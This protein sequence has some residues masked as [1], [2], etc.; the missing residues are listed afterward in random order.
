MSGGPQQGLVIHGPGGDLVGRLF[1]AA[2]GCPGPTV[3]FAHG[4]PG[5]DQPYDLA[6]GLREAGW[7]A[8]VWHYRGCWGSSGTFSIAGMLSDIAAVVTDLCSGRHPEVDPGRLVIAGHSFGSWA[9]ITAALDDPR[10]RA[11]AAYGVVPEPSWCEDSL[12][13]LTAHCVP[14]LHGIT[15]AEYLEQYRAIDAS[16]SPVKRIAELAPRPLLLLHGGADTGVPASDA[17]KLFDRAA[18]PRELRIHPDA[19]HDFTGARH[20]LLAQ[21]TEWLG[22]AGLGPAEG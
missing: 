3:V 14:W 6:V 21:L 22:G 19:D 7:N 15:A 5:I 1:A 18:Q 2:P 20:W 10:I 17:R 12:D 9:A 4:V 8:V 11:V 13:D 16:Q